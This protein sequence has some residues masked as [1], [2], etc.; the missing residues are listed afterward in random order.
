[1]NK[2]RWRIS[3]SENNWQSSSEAFAI[4]RLDQQTDVLGVPAESLEGVEVCIGDCPA[5]DRP[6]LAKEAFQTL[7]VSII[8]AHESR[9]AADQRRD[10]KTGENDGRSQC[11][12]GR[13][14]N[15][16]GTAQA[17]NRGFRTYGFPTHAETEHDG[18]PDVANLPRQSRTRPRVDR[19]LHRTDRSVARVV[20][21]HCFV[22]RTPP[23]HSL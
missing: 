4:P 22:A 3:L 21:V 18:V 16:W 14:T 5:R 15:S 9:P 1:M 8:P 17:G 10:S 2:S 11:G 13:T 7:L 20:C 23:S 6:R 19:L 12:L